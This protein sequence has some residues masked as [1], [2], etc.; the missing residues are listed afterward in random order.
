MMQFAWKRALDRA[1]IDELHFHDLRHEAKIKKRPGDMRPAFS[2]CG[3][4]EGDN[5]TQ[6]RVHDQGTSNR[7]EPA[8][9]IGF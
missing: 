3:S 1:G 9:G 5:Q 4:A 6:G 7:R 2:S 8:G